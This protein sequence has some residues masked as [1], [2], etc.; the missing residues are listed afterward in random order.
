MQIRT[1]AFVSVLAAAAG[2]ASAQVHVEVGDAGNLAGGQQTGSGSLSAI[3]GVLDG[4]LDVDMYQIRVDDWAAFSATT[5]INGELAAPVEDDTQLFLFSSSG[6]GI[7]MNDDAPAPYT[8]FLSTLEAGSALY[9]GRTNGEIVW[10]AVSGYDSDPRAAGAL[11][12]FVDTPF[13]SGA[14]AATGP[15]AAGALDSWAGE[16][17]TPRGSYRISLTGASAVPA[18]G[19][20]AL[21]GLGGIVAGRRRRN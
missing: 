2:L 13:R 16:N 19:A 9:A 21:L 10:I 8:G 6:L 14:R 20:M 11:D 3:R 5:T 1:I 12:I 17:S 4:G 15:G 18:P 7:A